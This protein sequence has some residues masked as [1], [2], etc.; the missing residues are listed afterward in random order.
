MKK[1]LILICVFTFILTGILSA[2]SEDFNMEIGAV[3]TNH[4][5]H[6]I[7]DIAENA[8]QTFTILTMHLGGFDV[9]FNYRLDKQWYVYFSTMFAFNK[10]FVNDTQLGFGYNFQP[11]KGFNLFLGAGLALGGSVFKHTSNNITS[12]EEYFTVGGGISLLG[13]Y[14]FSRYIGIYFGISD[15]YYKPITGRHK[16]SDENGGAWTKYKITELNT[17]TKSINARAGVKVHF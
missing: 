5:L 11:G 7:G 15:S 10:M 13:S 17:F 1:K 3:Y 8:F 14:M 6:N 16:K 4:Q 2:K 9:G 12:Q